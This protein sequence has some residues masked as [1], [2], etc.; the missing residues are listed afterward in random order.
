VFD[1]H[2]PEAAAKY[3]SEGYIQHN[4]KVPTGRDGFITAMKDWF[5]SQGLAP[6]PVQPKNKHLPAEMVAQGDLVVVVWK[7]KA[8][9]PGKPGE[10]YEAF[11]FDMFRVKDGRFV[12]HWDGEL[13]Q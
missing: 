4:P 2:N 13:K 1:A 11:A 7:G 9:E 10:F 3:V 8:P 6:Q 5:R 12:E